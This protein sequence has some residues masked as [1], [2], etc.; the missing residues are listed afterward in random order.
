MSR[1]S[2][3]LLAFGAGAL[4]VSVVMVLERRSRYAAVPSQ[5]RPETSPRKEDAVMANPSQPVP[6]VPL[7]GRETVLGAFL[8][9]WQE[10]MEQAQI[11]PAE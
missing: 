4:A 7:P 8:H 1:S 9:A 3:F 2:H 5:P 6:E 11:S 10:A